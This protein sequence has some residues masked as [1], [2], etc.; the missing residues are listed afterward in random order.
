MSRDLWLLLRGRGAAVTPAA[1]AEMVKIT[2]LA[3]IV[4]LR[5]TN[6]EV[7]QRD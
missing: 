7:M 1:S 4:V 2:V 3:N 5:I 6:E